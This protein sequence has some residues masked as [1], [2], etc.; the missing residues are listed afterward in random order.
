MT[1]KQLIEKLQKIENKNRIVIVQGDGE[2][3]SYS[4]LAGVDAENVAYEEE[5]SWS[6]ICGLE[7]LTKELEEEHYGEEDVCDGVPAAVL[8]PIN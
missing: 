2:G 5:N 7:Y 8:F 6:V 1:V 4:P 3:N